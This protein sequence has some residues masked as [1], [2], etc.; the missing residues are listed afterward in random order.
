M[1]GVD[2]AILYFFCGK[3]AAGKSTLAKELAVA[4]D[5]ILLVEDEFLGTLFP[6]EIHDIQDYIRYSARVKDAL[7]GM[8]VSWL[9]R[10]VSVVLDFPGN[11]RNQRKWFRTICERAGAAHELHYIDAADEL[12]KAQLKQR[13][14]ALPDGAAFTSDAEFEAVTRYFQ[15]PEEDEGFVVIRHARAA[16]GRSLP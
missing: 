8:I 4:T 9:R 2:V 7:I 1:N 11:T 13:S 15:P 16:G 6:G 10:G 5:S 3:M 14:A 12:C